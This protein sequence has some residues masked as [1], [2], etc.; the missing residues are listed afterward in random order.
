M[1][2]A[3]CRMQDPATRNTFHVSRFTPSALS[4]RILLRA[5]AGPLRPGADEQTDARDLALPH[6]ALGLLAVATVATVH[7]SQGWRVSYLDPSSFILC[8]W[9]SC[10]FSSCRRVRVPSPWSLNAR[11]AG[12][13]PARSTERAHRQRAGRVRS[14]PGETGLAA[15]FGRGVSQRD[16][17]ADRAGAVGRAGAGCL[18]RAGDLARTATRLS[19]GGLVLVSRHAGADDWPGQSWGPGDGGSLYLHPGDW[20]VH[21][22]RLGPG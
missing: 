15:G 1:Q 10:P 21:P 12:Q 7:G 19:A 17:L 11:G 9:K 16:G 13:R 4:T 5:G 2:N 20:C 14:L 22:V 3:E 6:V 8:W 18:H